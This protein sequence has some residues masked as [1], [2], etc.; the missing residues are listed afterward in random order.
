MGVES[1]TVSPMRSVGACKQSRCQ[2]IRP[3]IITH[4]V[5]VD[6][7][8]NSVS[9]HASCPDRSFWWCN[10]WVVEA[11]V[12]C[13]IACTIPLATCD[14]ICRCQTKLRRLSRCDNGRRANAKSD[15]VDRRWDELYGEVPG[16]FVVESL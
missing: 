10:G 16:E 8:P 3:Q 2:S 14:L 12:S 9:L 6:V 1:T 4:T 7:V 5:E 15:K 11:G 13:F